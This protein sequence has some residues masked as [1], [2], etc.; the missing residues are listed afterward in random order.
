[1]CK[2]YLGFLTPVCKI[3]NEY[4]H[5]GFTLYKTEIAQKHVIVTLSEAFTAVQRF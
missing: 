4:F 1:M 3:M 5:T 2:V